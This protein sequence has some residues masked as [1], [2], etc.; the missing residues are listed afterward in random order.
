AMASM[1]SVAYDV[2]FR[3]LPYREPSRLVAVYERNTPRQRDRNVVSA[4]ALE[5]WRQRSHTLDSVTG[6]MPSSR[7]F[8]TAQGAERVSGAEVTAS[9]FALLGR[10]PM[11][12]SAFWTNPV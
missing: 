3:P 5:A 9:Y 6:L 2:V 11:F 8:V 1:A 7:T 4:L 12:G 10:S